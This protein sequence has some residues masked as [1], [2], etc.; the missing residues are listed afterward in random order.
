[1]Q[2]TVEVICRN[3]DTRIQAPLGTSL[4]DLARQTEHKGPYPFLAAYVNNRI[5][6]LNYRV[7]RPVTV[8]FIDVTSFEGY[9]VYQRTI[10]FI[11]QKAV[12]DL[13]P[14][15]KF[16]IRHSLGSGFYCEFGDG[17][18]IDSEQCEALRRR[19][20]DIIA[21]RYPITRRT[22]LT[23]EVNGIYER[24]GFDDK[25]ALLNTRPRL[26]SDLYRL[27]DMV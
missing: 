16:Y 21:R 5:K 19:I 12:W 11:L 6:E 10:S 23:E 25:V 4:L 15:R 7:M 17:Q 27:D 26:Y 9:R 8:E 20:S 3:S 2:N 13:F 24:F 22:M 14:G 18:S 1:M